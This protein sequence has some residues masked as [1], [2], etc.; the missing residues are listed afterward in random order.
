MILEHLNERSLIRVE[1]QDVRDFL[2]GLITND[3]HHLDCGGSMYTM[4]LNTKG[5]VLYDT[6][7]YKTEE[8]NTYYV[9]CEKPAV[10]PIQKH[11]KMYRIRRKVNV[12]NLDAE[13]VIY[14]LFNFNKVNL[15]TDRNSKLNQF[16]G[17][18]VP[19]D[20][21]N[22]SLPETSSTTKMYKDLVIFKDPRVVELGSRIISKTGTDIKK[23]ISEMIGNVEAPS[24]EMNY[25]IFRYS[26]GV[27]EGFNDLPV[28]NCFPLECNC[29]YLHGISFHKGCYIGQEVTARTHHTGVVRKR[30]MPLY[31]TQIPTKLPADNIIL[32][33]KVNLG[34]LRGIEGSVGLALLRISKAL[35]FGQLAVG[36]GVAKVIKP[37][38]WPVEAP[39][40]KVNV[41][42]N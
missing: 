25:K 18:I 14:S 13:Y 24:A 17:V 1:G 2:Q 6:I 16:E 34:R 39:K 35:D 26:L 20:K 15:N 8:S 5:R 23:Q 9:E 10:E 36:N 12:S 22:S 40:E 11:L 29:D 21:L 19:C 7:I 33:E 28:G 38:W 31:F 3:I 42:R 41:E 27:G 4:F 30:L 37:S 32:H